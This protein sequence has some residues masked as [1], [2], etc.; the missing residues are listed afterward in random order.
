MKTGSRKWEIDQARSEFET[1]EA[2][3]KLAKEDYER[4]DAL[5]RRTASAK[6]DF[7]FAKSILE[8]RQGLY[9]SALA[10][11]K[12]S[13]EGFRQEDKDEA[14]AQL[15]QAQANYD[16]LMAWTRKEERDEADAR[17][18]EAKAKLD[19]INTN[20]KE[21][22]V[23]AKEDWVLEV[24]AVRKGDVVPP[25]QPIIR[26]LRRDDLWVKVYVPETQLGKVRL[27]QSVEVTVDSHPDKRF[28]GQVTQIN[29]ISEFTPRN[30][31][32]IDERHNQVFGVRVRV[33]DPQGVFKSGMAAEVIVPLHE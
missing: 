32:S 3:L 22:E 24:V 1:A 17:L 8:R 14:L 31:Q 7:E 13:E 4:A 26:A 20:L 29:S 21:A 25:N 23:V 6:A 9:S 19:E 30:V 2:D 28:K 27:W 10:K 5:Y 16:L 12:M 15:K 18:A 11:Y 33:E